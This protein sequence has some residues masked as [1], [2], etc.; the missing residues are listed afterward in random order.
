M[1]DKQ[2]KMTKRQWD[3]VKANKP[4]A[5]STA[6]HSTCETSPLV[7]TF[8][9]SSSLREITPAKQF[10]SSSKMLSDLVKHFSFILKC[11]APKKQSQQNILASALK[12]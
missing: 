10:R 5:K 11:L 4:A 6:Q 3:I 12:G 8:M 7:R 9:V 2:Q 1:S